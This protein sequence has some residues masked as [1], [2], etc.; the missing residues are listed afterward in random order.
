M[1]I[2]ESHNLVDRAREMF[3]AELEREEILEVK[4]AVEMELS[5]CAKALEKISSQLSRLT[6]SEEWAERNGMFI[7]KSAP[8]AVRR[9]LKIFLSEAEQWLIRNE[10]AEFKQALLDLYFRVLRFNAILD[11]Y[12][13]RYI[14]TFDKEAG[15]LRLFCI[16]PSAL[17]RD[18]LKRTGSSVFFS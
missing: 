6:K 13:E 1:L 15:R 2:D 5:G 12:D 11:L 18:A 4:R 7:N 9:L 14:T 16:D 8:E 3:S 10:G 17:L